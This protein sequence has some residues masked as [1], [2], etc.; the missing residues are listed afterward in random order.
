V[1]EA[2]SV[3]SSLYL[4][5]SQKQLLLPNVSV[6]EVVG[7]Q[8]PIKSV[9]SPDHFLGLVRWRGIDIP[10]ISYEIANGQ[11][12]SKKVDNARIV[13][14]NTIGEHHNDLPFFAIVTQGIPRL[15][16]VSDDLIKKTK[17]KIG[18]ADAAIVRVDGEEATIPNIEYLE[19]LAIN[20]L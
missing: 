6:A 15:V 20:Q 2:Q 9:E 4:P 5:V 19:S 10:V 13:V 17:K 1:S 7:Y 16:K 8:Q 3:I 18:E 11:K 12:V 14:I